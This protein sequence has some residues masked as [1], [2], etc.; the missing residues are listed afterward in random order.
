MYRKEISAPYPQTIYSLIQSIIFSLT[1]TVVHS[2]NHLLSRSSG[3]HSLVLPFFFLYS[4]ILHSNEGLTS[5][6][7]VF[8]FLLRRYLTQNN[9]LYNPFFFLF[10]HSFILTFT[11]SFIHPPP[12][13]FMHL[14]IQF[15]LYD[16]HA[17]IRHL[18]KSFIYFTC[19]FNYLKLLATI[20]YTV[21]RWNL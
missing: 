20:T 3:T 11:S 21:F 15:D 5:K 6:A 19:L 1:Y 4:L 10:I 9:M 7:L 8:F 14:L 18:T 17:H 16:S 12:D 13:S 2:L